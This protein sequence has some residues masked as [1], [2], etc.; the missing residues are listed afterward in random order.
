MASPYD[1]INQ[2]VN[3]NAY[4]EF[5]T[6]SKILIKFA[7]NILENPSESKYRRIRISNPT[8]QNKLLN[9]AGGMECLFEMGF[10]EAEDG[11]CLMLP[12]TASLLTLKRMKEDLSRSREKLE[13]PNQSVKSSNQSTLLGAVGGV[14]TVGGEGAVGV[15]ASQ[16]RN[17]TQTSRLAQSY[18]ETEAAFLSRLKDGMR[19]VMNYEK[20]ELQQKAR[21]IIPCEQLQSEAR[22]KYEANARP[23]PN[24]DIRDYLLL[25]L[26]H[27]FKTSFFH[28]VDTLPCFRCNGQT[29][30]TGYTAPSADDMRWGASRVESHQCNVCGHTNRFPRYTNAEKLLETC[31][32][33]CGEWAECFTLCCRAL[34]FEARYV[35]DWTDHVWTEVYSNSQSRWLHCDPCE[36][37][38]DK[39]LLYE[40]G[41]GKKLTYVIAMS[42]DEIQD[43]TWRY[44]LKHQEVL[45]RRTLCREN[46]LRRTIHQLWK[47]KISTLTAEKQKQLW[48]RLICELTEFITIKNENTE[49]LPG[50]S[51]GSL[52]W[53]EAR[54]ELGRSAPGQQTV[55]NNFVF[56]PTE[57]EREC[58][59]IHVTYNCATDKYI[60][61]SSDSEQR[62]GWQACTFSAQD[63]FRKEELDW[64]MAYLA[65]CEGSAY[66]EVVWKFDLTDTDLRIS[67]MELKAE[68]AIFENGAISWRLCAGDNCFM[69]NGASLNT[70]MTFDLHGCQTLTITAVLQGGRGENAWQHAQLFRQSTTDIENCP[71]EL[72]LFLN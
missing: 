3:E 60:R 57:A 40:S 47:Q 51:T 22:L 8:I 41:W 32:G 62:M 18:L 65:R 44:V 30:N 10:Q 63:V 25:S 5:M 53:R 23:S 1:S 33:R 67:K 37:I 21:N 43:V 11:E 31:R 2:L 56:R 71:F 45:A 59:L 28:W 12:N 72:K 34:D 52:V 16:P 39:P 7:V 50:R 48:H 15:V 54:G 55:L 27:W 69:Q 66:A 14:G 13:S 29:Q 9:V 17:H 6:A 61:I 70:L 36:N 19:R 49:H 46:W 26:L 38:C 35:M 64:R 24:L 58:E 42:K 4:E 68:S 20:P